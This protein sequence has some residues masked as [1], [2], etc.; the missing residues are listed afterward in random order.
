[1]A[2]RARVPVAARER[3]VDG[4]VGLVLGE[5]VREQREQRQEHGYDGD[6][7]R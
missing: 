6:R 1:M 2:A 5:A 4:A 7:D 3:L